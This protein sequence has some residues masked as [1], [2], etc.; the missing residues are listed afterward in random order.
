M[1]PK[2]SSPENRL[3]P[4]QRA[5]AAF[6]EEFLQ[7]LGKEFGFDGS[8]PNI[9]QSV[10]NIAEGYSAVRGRPKHPEYRKEAASEYSRLKKDTE[11]FL[12][13]LANAKE[14]AIDTDMDIF[15]QL[16][17]SKKSISDGENHLM[18]EKGISRKFDELTALLNL[19][20]ATTE[21]GKQLYSARPGPKTDVALEMLVRRA[22][23]FWIWE[24]GR[25]FTIDHH[26]G[27]G[28]TKSF[29]FL[30]ALASHVDGNISDTQL[31]SA[32]RADRKNRR[33]LKAGPA[34]K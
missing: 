23:N 14:I 17:A 16:Q 7:R 10:R 32:M 5:L 2:K 20:A 31:V 9:A 12:E 24:L 8:N 30:R 29:Q 26:Q 22:G 21:H 13:I 25:K 3:S 18:P 6:D 15:A 27:T 33:K 11:K 34:K 4:E 28:T 19:L 1:P